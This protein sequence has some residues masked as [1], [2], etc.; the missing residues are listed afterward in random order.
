M[1]GALVCSLCQ[2]YHSTL[3]CTLVCVVTLYLYYF[4]SLHK[5]VKQRGDLKT[6]LVSCVK[7]AAAKC[8]IHVYSVEI[9]RIVTSLIV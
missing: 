5:D 1:V 8:Y 6:L 9:V 4:Y 7:T 2:G 3:L